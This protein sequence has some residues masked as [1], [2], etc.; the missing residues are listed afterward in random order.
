MAGER[1]TQTGDLILLA[2]FIPPGISE[3]DYRKLETNA[4]KFARAFV[5]QK[6]R[7]T[8]RVGH[9]DGDKSRFYILILVRAQDQPIGEI[10]L[11]EVFNQI[12]QY[13]QKPNEDTKKT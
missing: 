2:V 6:S 12:G 10:D 1:I 3:E 8:A 5:D 4:G 13:L 11:A 9:F 7:I